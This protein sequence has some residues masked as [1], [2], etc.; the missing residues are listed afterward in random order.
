MR[1]L[2]GTGLGLLISRKYIWVVFVS[3]NGVSID[4]CD[5]SNTISMYNLLTYGRAI[6]E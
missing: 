4:K 1:K 6:K 2:F 5:P 3:D